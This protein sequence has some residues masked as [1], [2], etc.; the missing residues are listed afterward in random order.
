MAFKS[1]FVRRRG[2]LTAF[3]FVVLMTFGHLGLKHPSLAGMAQAIEAKISREALHQRFT[4]HAVL[5]MQECLN[6]VLNQKVM[7]AM[8]LDAALLRPF[9]RVLIFDSSGWVVDPRL[10]T[11]LPGSGGNASAASCKLQA[12]YEYKC[13]QLGFFH[14]SP[15][16]IPDQAYSPTLPGL[17]DRGDLVLADMGYFKVKTFRQHHDNGVFFLSRFLVG[18]TIRAAGTDAAMDLVNVLKS[19]TGDFVEKD[20]LLGSVRNEQTP[21]R[22]ICMRVNEQAANKRRRKMFKKAGEDGRTP[23]KAHLDMCD[24]TLLITNAPASL[25][26]AAMAYHLYRVRWQIEL[27]FKQFKSVMRIHKSDTGNENRLRC[28]LYGKMIMAVL[29]HRV[30]ARLQ[31]GLWNSQRREVSFDKLYKRFQERAF[32]MLR[33]CL[34]T[35]SAAHSFLNKEIPRMLNACFKTHQLSRQTTLQRLAQPPNFI[36]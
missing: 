10:K 35:L 15:G 20:V 28:E 11:V 14:V 4:P 3:D 34:I 12:G 22:L 27:I 25:L 6:Y 24:W 21:C 17:A 16:I 23:S 36:P 33:K 31:N 32:V 18:T 1:G 2:K 8:P 30:H 5:L 29:I 19:F 26:P 9:R 13:G 7:S